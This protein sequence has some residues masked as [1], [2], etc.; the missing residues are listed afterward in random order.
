[1]NSAYNGVMSHPI[2]MND[3]LSLPTTERLQI[4]EAIWDSI[5]ADPDSLHVTDAQRRA[6]EAR[7][8]AYR[9]DPCMAIPCVVSPERVPT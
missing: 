5:A 4:V 9:K 2:A 1:M 6:I 7:L 8:E 3:I